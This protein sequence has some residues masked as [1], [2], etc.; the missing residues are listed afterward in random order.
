MYDIATM[1][2]FLLAGSLTVLPLFFSQA[3]VQKVFI[4]GDFYNKPLLEFIQEIE[5]AHGV[6]FQYV[7]DVVKDIVLTGVIKHN[8]TLLDGLEILLRDKPI[9]FVAPHENE[10][11][12]FLNDKKIVK[13]Q[14]SFYK[15]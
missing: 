1:I 4:K 15:L 14:E 11:V 2:R 3:Q 13:A 5:H 6:Q 9:S 8:T 12:F 10:I 7:D